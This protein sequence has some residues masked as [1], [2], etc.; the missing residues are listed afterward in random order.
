[1]NL[2]DHIADDV[3]SAM[4]ARDQERLRVLRML[5]AAIRQR[6]IDEQ[7]ELSEAETLTVVEKMIK[8][9]RESEKQYRDADRPELADAELAEIA[10]LEAYLPEQ[11]GEQELENAITAAIRETA[12]AGMQDMGKVMGA[13]KTRLAGRADMGAVSGMV[14]QRLG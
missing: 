2:K 5:S 1:M 4:R 11:V 7:T 8:Q 10:V 13:L 9:R 6:E 12:A 14:K 3:K